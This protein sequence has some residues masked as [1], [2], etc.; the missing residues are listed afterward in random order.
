MKKK[1]QRLIYAVTNFIDA[2]DR[3]GY[4]GSYQSQYKAMKHALN[5][6]VAKTIAPNVVTLETRKEMKERVRVLKEAKKLRIPV[7]KGDNHNSGVMTKKELKAEIK[8]LKANIE[9]SRV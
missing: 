1:Y 5:N 9:K 2:N 4:V 3:I 8:A 7:Y 6:A